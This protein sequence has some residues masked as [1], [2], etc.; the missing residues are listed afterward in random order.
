MSAINQSR[1]ANGVFEL[2]DGRMKSLLEIPETLI[3][4]NNNNN[5][6]NLIII[7][8][9]FTEHVLPFGSFIILQREKAVRMRFRKDRKA[10]NSVKMIVIM[11][12]I[13]SHIR[14]SLREL[15]FIYFMSYP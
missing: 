13:C 14:M 7:F 10:P 12:S 9:C 1:T 15:N 11:Q 4:F 3:Y 6:Y 8:S 2:F 5:C